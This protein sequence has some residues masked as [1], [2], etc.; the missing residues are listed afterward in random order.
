MMSLFFSHFLLT[1][2]GVPLAFFLE[3][4][5]GVFRDA[6][7]VLGGY[8]QLFMST[9]QQGFWVVLATYLRTLTLCLIGCPLLIF[10]L[11][12]QPACK[13]SKVYLRDYEEIPAA[14]LVVIAACL[15]V[16]AM[17]WED[18]R[19]MVLGEYKQR[20]GTHNLFWSTAS[21]SRVPH[22]RGICSMLGG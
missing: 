14:C 22:V 20:I 18:T 17:C 7:S 4:H 10:F 5:R 12:G 15:V 19:S 8:S 21:F 2:L 13:V 1:C 11:Q 3:W 16:P 6:R 9:T